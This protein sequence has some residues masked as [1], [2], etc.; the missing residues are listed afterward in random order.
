MYMASEWARN[1]LADLPVGICTRFL[2]AKA[3]G[4]EVVVEKCQAQMPEG[5]MEPDA[6]SWRRFWN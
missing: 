6:Q 1:V 2:G 5:K 3:E 4:V